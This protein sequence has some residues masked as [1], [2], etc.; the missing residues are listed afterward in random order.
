M[1]RVNQ[2]KIKIEEVDQLESNI[3]KKLRLKKED[4]MTYTI[5]RKNIDARDKQQ[6]YFVYSVNVE[7]NNE[8]RVSK[9]KDVLMIQSDYIDALPYINETKKPIIVGFG[10]AGI[11]C[12]LQLAQKG[13]QPI[14]LE[15]GEKIEDR[16]IS[17][18]QFFEQAILNES[19]NIQF[20]EGGAGTYSD[21]KLTAR[22]KDKR[23][24]KVYETLIEFGAPKEIAYEGLPHIGSDLLKGIIK[25]IRAEIIALGG[26]IH[27]ETC[28]HSLL[29]QEN[30]VIGVL[31]NGK[32]LFSEQVVLAIGN[33]SRS[34]IR[35]LHAQNV[36][37]QQKDLAIGFRMEHKQE[38]INKASYHDFYNHPSLQAA[39]YH[40]ASK[41]IN[42]GVYTFC[43]CPGGIVVAATSV[44]KHLCV[45]GMSNYKRDEENANSAI[46]VQV[47]ASDYGEG[48]FAGLEFIEA[49]EQAAYVLGGSNYHAPVQLVKDFLDD[50]TSTQLDTII[51]SYPI[52]YRLSNLNTL[53][54][55]P[56][57][58][59]LKAGLLDFNKK[60]KGFSEHALLTGVETRSSSPI[61]ILRDK[62]SLQSI[63]TL[64]LYPCGEGAGY[65]GG[66]V[67]S[68]IDGLKVAEK[69]LELYSE[70][71]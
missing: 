26:S 29:L 14:V 38:F 68:A 67:S 41:A 55:K 35:M 11:F 42:K 49:I 64:G 70:R 66:I 10:P 25:K 3:R 39:S 31:A 28:V 6:I 2:I 61:T 4:K 27:F 65:A 71:K 21:G 5:H 45:N 60:I 47:N 22:T 46:L 9:L 58:D 1:I 30:K 59:N 62:Q 23:I 20:G 24:H 69:L 16:D 43:M 54:S 53:L 8:A 36:A 7:I 33:S 56:L 19:S 15:Q 63:S 40:L 57:C 17:V 13:C 18:K 51:P 50:K 44:K 12:A 32:K 37:M 48:V 52:G 34:F